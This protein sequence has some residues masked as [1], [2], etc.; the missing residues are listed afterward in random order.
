MAFLF[1]KFYDC[2][3]CD[4]MLMKKEEKQMEEQKMGIMPI[5]KLLITMAAPM[6]LSM[7]IGAL[8]NIVDSIFVSNFSED[9]LTAVSLAFPVQNIIVAIGTGAG[10][11]INALLSRLLGEKNQL[12]VNKT[13]HNGLILSFISYFLVLIFGIFCVKSS[14]HYCKDF[15]FVMLE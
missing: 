8:Y 14:R 12:A 1:L 6:I 13:A 10:V 3:E 7:M 11:G 4:N 2:K 9:A 5:N 15:C